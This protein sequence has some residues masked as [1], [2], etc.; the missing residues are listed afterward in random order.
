MKKPV[1]QGSVT[2]FDGVFD[3]V[4]LE[5]VIEQLFRLRP[6]LNSLDERLVSS[7]YG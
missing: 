3:G 4:S 2:G 6:V 5:R 7:S 1:T